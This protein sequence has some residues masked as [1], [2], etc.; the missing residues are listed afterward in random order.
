MSTPVTAAL[1]PIFWLHHANID[2]LWQV[3]IDRNGNHHDPDVATWRDG[4]FD[5]TF[6]MPNPDGSGSV[7]S[8]REMT[9]TTSPGLGYVYDDVS[10]PLNGANRE[11]G[12]LHNILQLAP[13]AKAQLT[14]VPMANAKPELLGAAPA[15]VPLGAGANN[16]AHVDLDQ[17]GSKRVLRNFAAAT[18]GALAGEADRVFLNLEGIR[19]RNDSAVFKVYVHNPQG[20]GAA[21]QA[22]HFVGT[23]SLFGASQAAAPDGQHGGNGISQVFEITELVDTMV[24]GGAVELPALAVR[25]EAC[26]PIRPNDD[27]A[28]DRVSVY[29]QGS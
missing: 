24:L 14:G 8:P 18:A 21:A 10:D 16:F 20:Q 15:P 6:A 4:P 3:W 19:G 26:T 25:L 23:F 11:T 9:D 22:E 13:G 27:I 2:R 29:R 28:I 1:D 12:R 7:F 5:R 17:A